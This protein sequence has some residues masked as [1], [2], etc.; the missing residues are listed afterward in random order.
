MTRGPFTTRC[1]LVRH[2]AT[3]DNLAGRYAGKRSDAPLCARGVAELE[4]LRASDRLAAEP[5][6][7]L[8]S[9]SRRCV[10]TARV[11]F[12]NA[13]YE[14]AHDLE[15][16]DFGEFE[17]KTYQELSGSPEYQKWI[18][19]NGRRPFPG[20]ESLDAFVARSYGAFA[21]AVAEN[22]EKS[23]VVLVCHGGS[24]MAILSRLTGREYFS[25]QV[26]PAEGF[27]V[28]VE[29]DGEDVRFISYR[30]V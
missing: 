19:S 4:R 10:E 20:G 14:L 23:P 22:H 11:L 13:P 16:I 24:I 8:V 6:A 21:K 18:D 1:V 15:E 29:V 9:P 2:G 3:A 12:P 26:P 7:L 28:T 30:R 25:F 17:G 5:G 27:E